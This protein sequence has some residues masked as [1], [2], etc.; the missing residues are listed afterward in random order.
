MLALLKWKTTSLQ[1]YNSVFIVWDLVEIRRRRQVSSLLSPV[2]RT[3]E[4]ADSLRRHGAV[5]RFCPVVS[6]LAMPYSTIE[7]LPRKL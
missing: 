7:P 4:F 5:R 6:A 2:L 1:F 3:G